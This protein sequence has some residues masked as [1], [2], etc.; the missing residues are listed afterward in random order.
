MLE[1]IAI[2]VEALALALWTG[3]MAGFAFIFAPIAFR[4]IGNM[5]TFGAVTAGV[6]RALS[7]FGVVCGVV[8]IV[9]SLGRSYAPESVRLRGLRNLLVIVAFAATAY[10]QN[11]I[12][13]RMEATAAQIPG[14]IDSVPKED[15]R[16]AA[17]DAEHDASTRV[18]GLAFL[19]VAAATALV[20]FGRTRKA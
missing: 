18:Y 4:T 12:L 3:A 1:R 10:E 14:A 7:T 15:P 19:C 11:A 8:A 17:Y 5:T 6:L 20:A 9:A 16:R 13:P 2:A